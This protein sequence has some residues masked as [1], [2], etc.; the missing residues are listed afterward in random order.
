MGHISYYKP[1]LLSLATLLVWSSRE[2]EGAASSVQAPGVS[3]S[4]LGSSGIVSRN[5]SSFILKSSNTFKS[6][7]GSY[8]GRGRPW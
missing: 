3:P 8:S 7:G 5:L 1:G 6:G 2:L 4:I